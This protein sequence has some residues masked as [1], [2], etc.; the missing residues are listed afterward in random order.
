MHLTTW[1]RA[2]FTLE[3]SI[4]SIGQQLSFYCL[5]FVFLISTFRI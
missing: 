4:V 3:W 5:F 2:L 1:S